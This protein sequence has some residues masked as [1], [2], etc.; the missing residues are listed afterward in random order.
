M[1]HGHGQRKAGEPTG[2]HYGRLLVML[3]L[4]WLSMYALM[5]AMV[6]RFANALP[7]LNQAFMA[8]IMV[9]PMA[10][11]ELLLMGS[12]YRDRRRNILVYAVA[13]LMLVGAWTAIRSQWQIGDRQFLRSMIPHHAGAILMCK[14][15]SIRDA[16]I[17]AL[18]RQILASQQA[19]ID[20]MRAKLAALDDR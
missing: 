14:E 6:D 18:C 3:G 4:S 12:M 15:A 13:A 11:L 9:A 10:I 8:A 17:E 20:Q 5:Y 1:K 19:E 7:N 2:G 16:E